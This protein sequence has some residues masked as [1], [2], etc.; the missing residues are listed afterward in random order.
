MRCKSQKLRLA[1]GWPGCCASAPAAAAECTPT[2]GRFY[3][4]S[5]PTADL[6][7]AALGHT[8]DVFVIGVLP[9]SELRSAANTAVRAAEKKLAKLR[10]HSRN[11]EKGARAEGAPPPPASSSGV[12]GRR[13]GGSGSGFGCGLGGGGPK[14][15]PPLPPA[16]RQSGGG[17]GFGFVRPLAQPTGTLQLQPISC[18]STVPLGAGGV[19]EWVAGES[20]GDMIYA[21]TASHLVALR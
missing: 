5:R 21:R 7:V 10:P 17:P 13:G 14:S 9:T 6:A 12:G 18:A 19:L 8:G 16:S 15:S 4:L 11:G 2:S 1:L 20:P 3:S